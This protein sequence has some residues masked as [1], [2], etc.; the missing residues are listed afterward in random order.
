MWFVV[1]NPGLKAGDYI[2]FLDSDQGIPD[3]LVTK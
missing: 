3:A 2:A 1:Q